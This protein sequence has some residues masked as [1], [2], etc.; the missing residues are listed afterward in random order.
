MEGDCYGCG[1]DNPIGLGLEFVAD[2]DDRLAA[3]FT[4]RPEHHGAPGILHGGVTA[5]VLD[6]TMAALGF[7]IDGVHCMTATLELKFRKPVPIDGSTLRA[8]SWRDRQQESRRQRVHGRLLLAD[9]TV[10]AEATGIF[11]QMRPNV[12]ED[13]P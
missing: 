4:P 3:T 6:E 7:V 1:D 9:G 5:T 13:A 12:Q 11:V 2:G 8:E 10:A